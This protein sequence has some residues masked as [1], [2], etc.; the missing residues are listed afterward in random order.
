MLTDE[1]MSN[2]YCWLKP[3]IEHVEIAVQ[4]RIQRED[5]LQGMNPVAI[6]LFQNGR[7]AERRQEMPC[8][9]SIN[10]LQTVSVPRMK[11]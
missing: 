6:E 4:L 11:S 2:T 3:E 7:M 5:V 9:R 8:V 1:Q 10:M